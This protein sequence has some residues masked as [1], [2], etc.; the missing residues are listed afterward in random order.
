MSSLNNLLRSFSNER[1]GSL[2]NKVPYH[3]VENGVMHT[4]S[5]YYMSGFEV[6]FNSTSYQGNYEIIMSRLHFAL[7]RLLPEP[8]RFRLVYYTE[9]LDESVIRAYEK[10]ISATEPEGRRFLKERAK[11]LR[12]AWERG[13]LLQLRA[14]VVLRLNQSGDKDAKERRAITLR[15]QVMRQFESV[16]FGTNA[17]DDS[18][19]RDLCHTYFNPDFKGCDFAPYEQNGHFFSKKHVEK[20]PEAAASTFRAQVCKSAIENIDLDQIRV[21]STYCR[22]LTLHTIPSPFTQEAMIHAI[23]S[24]G[25]GFCAVIDI[26]AE[27]KEDLYQA[28]VNKNKWYQNATRSPIYVDEETFSLYESSRE[29]MRIVNEENQKFVKVSMGLFLF[30][31]DEEQLREKQRAVYSA[32][33]GIPGNPFMPLQYGVAKAYFAFAPFTGSEHDQQPVMPSGNA[34]HFLPV[35]GPWK[36]NTTEDKFITALRN[37]YYGVTLLDTFQ[38]GGNY[39]GIITG[40]SRSGKSFGAAFMAS[41][42]LANKDHSLAIIDVGLGYRYLVDMFEGSY[43]DTA[44]ECWNPFALPPGNVQPTQEDV[45]DTL[46]VLFTM[47]PPLPGS[48]GDIQRTMIEYTIRAVYNYKARMGTGELPTLSDFV[49]RLHT[50]DEINSVKLTKHQEGL[51]EGLVISFGLWTGQ[52][53]YGR[54]FDGQSDASIF[55]ARVVYFDISGLLTDKRLAP[56]GITAVANFVKKYMMRDTRPTVL[57]ADELAETMKASEMMRAFIETLYATAAKHI[58]GIW[59]LS[60][61]LDAF[62]DVMFNNASFHLAFPSQVKEQIYWLERWGLPEEVLALTKSTKKQPGEFSQAMCFMRDGDGV[63]GDIVTVYPNQYDLRV[64]DSEKDRVEKT[65]EAVKKHGDI[66]SAVDNENLEAA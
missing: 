47:V 25:S 54:L 42:F 37:N 57:L 10:R 7:T 8:C 58:A 44:R 62:S 24:A 32:L 26:Y 36:G 52:S 45:E 33:S 63:A 34:V 4:H 18:G 48:D 17:L 55:S 20:H 51:R 9:D 61:N 15:D 50:V 65:M 29:A 30:G 39:N 11:S 2:T 1:K 66:F 49:A 35:T 28:Q 16:G 5:P 12:E 22:A 53:Q 59:G 38:R 40:Q 64:F 60:Q 3:E 41:E 43:K 14:F 19:I 13:E 56:V 6:F 23:D 46:G 27:P 31:E 21:G